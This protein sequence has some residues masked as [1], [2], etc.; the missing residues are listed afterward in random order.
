MNAICFVNGFSSKFTRPN[1]DMTINLYIFFA[2][3]ITE[4]IH[5]SHIFPPEALVTFHVKI[6]FGLTKETS[7]KKSLLLLSET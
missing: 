7:N 5:I 6:F 2:V 1:V 4:W 3:G